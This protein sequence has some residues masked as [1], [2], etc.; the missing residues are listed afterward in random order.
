MSGLSLEHVRVVVDVPQSMLEPIRN[1][2]KANVYVGERTIAAE[3]LTFFPVADAATNTFRVRA[4]LPAASV[5]LY[6]GTFV[7]VGFVVGETERLLV[8][9]SAIVRRSELTAVYVVSGD[10][11]TLRQVR[12]GRRYGERIEVL[13][14]LEAGEVIAADPVAAGV[15]L[16]ERR[17]GQ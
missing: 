2:G 4:S 16:Q 15:Y 11:V 9:L 13:A 14:G 5:T 17:L 10:A 7:K 8:P 3:S 1:I 6:P 12:S